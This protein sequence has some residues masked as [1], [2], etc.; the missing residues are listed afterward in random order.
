MNPSLIDTSGAVAR[1]TTFYI[2]G[3]ISIGVVV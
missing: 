1:F 2:A 3:L